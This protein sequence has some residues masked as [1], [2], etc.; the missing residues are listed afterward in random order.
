[1]YANGLAQPDPGDFMRQ[2]LSTEIASKDN[3]WQGRNITRWRNAEY[4]NLYHAA[5]CETDPVKTRRALYRDERFGHQGDGGYSRCPPDGRCCGREPIA[6]LAVR[7]GQLYLEPLR[8]VRHELTASHASDPARALRRR[9]P[10]RSD[11]SL[12]SSPADRPSCPNTGLRR[13]GPEERSKK[14]RGSA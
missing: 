7:M 3:K 14:L 5:E 13:Q 8:L 1:M 10:F 9:S 4:D 12:S 2:F 6:R 11:G